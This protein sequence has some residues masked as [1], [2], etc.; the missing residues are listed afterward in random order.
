VPRTPPVGP[1][2]PGL[3]A[4]ALARRPYDLRHAAPSLRLNASGASAEV[5]ARAGSSARGL[6]DVYL[7]CIS[8]QDDTVSQ[9][10]EDALDPGAGAPRPSRCGKAS[11]YAHRRR[12]PG[13]CPLTCTRTG[14]MSRAWPT[15]AR[16]GRLATP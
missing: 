8:G 3:A 16:S 10:I 4:T 6:H 9:R 1:L 12:H 14:S 5:A 13:P 7:N 11:G 2:G 15:A